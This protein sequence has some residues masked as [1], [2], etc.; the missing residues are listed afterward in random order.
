MQNRDCKFGH[1]TS[2]AFAHHEMTQIIRRVK[3]CASSPVAPQGR[4]LGASYFL[5]SKKALE[6]VCFQGLVADRVG[7]EPTVPLRVHL[8]S[9]Q[10]RYN[11]F[12]TC[13]YALP[14]WNRVAIMPQLFA[15]CKPFSFVVPEKCKN[16]LTALLAR[17]MMHK[18]TVFRKALSQV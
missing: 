9:S 1:E 6:N 18:L 10:G 14:H 13:P 16:V 7:F 5:H 4:G 11:H 3:F 2:R 12:D 15:T 8:I 17:G